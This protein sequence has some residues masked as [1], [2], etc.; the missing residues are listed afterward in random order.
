MRDPYDVVRGLEAFGHPDT[1]DSYLGEGWRERIPE[2]A[3]SDP[4]DWTEN[5]VVSMGIAYTITG[6]IHKEAAVS[7]EVSKDTQEPF[8]NLG[9]A[10]R[11]VENLIRGDTDIFKRNQF[12]DV[13]IHASYDGGWVVDITY[14]PGY[15]ADAWHDY[16]PDWGEYF[17]EW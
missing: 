9:D 5:E 13:S 7:G 14:S 10:L 12:T 16:N 3:K 6:G 4:Y 11:Y 2:L 1:L 15:D 8:S 17:D